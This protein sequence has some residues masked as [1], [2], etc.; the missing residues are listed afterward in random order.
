MNSP[1][2][3]DKNLTYNVDGIYFG[4]AAK[5]RPVVYDID[6]KTVI[7]SGLAGEVF[8]INT[9]YNKVPSADPA[10]WEM[11]KMFTSTLTQNVGPISAPIALSTDKKDNVWAFFGTGRYLSNA[12]KTDQTQQYFYGVKDPYFNNAASGYYMDAVSNL[13]LT[14]DD[15]FDASPYAVGTNRKVKGVTGIDNWADLLDAARQEHG[16]HHAL[17]A[18]SGISS[19][20]VVSKAT[21]LGGIVFFPG[22]TP[23]EDL[24]GFG[25][26]TN[27][28]AMYYETGTAYYKHI[29]PGTGTTDTIGG[30][31]TKRVD[32]KLFVGHG[33]PPP[34][35]GFHVGRESGATAFLQM[36]TG[37]VVKINVD[38]AFPIKSGIA[39]WRDKAR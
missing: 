38:T 13:E 2:A 31:S 16:W 19:E 17:E 9:H 21:V 32:N 34:A 26:D 8:K 11:E 5:V 18:Y 37:E 12:D 35:A 39:A 24:C 25:G 7:D 4:T 23:N 33:A 30:E 28:Y 29:L 14:M 15:L 22:Y 27:Y 1:V 10:D 36:S 6:G 20:R 3:F